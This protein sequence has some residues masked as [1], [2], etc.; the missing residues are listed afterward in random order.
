MKAGVDLEITPLG[1]I[2]V[3]TGNDFSRSLGWGPE[4]TMLLEYHYRSLK[5][6]IRK[7]LHASIRDFDLWE[8]IAEI[9]PS[10]KF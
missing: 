3:G 4:K 9:Y 2:P 8:M 1:I 7:W 5:K 10:G 6:L